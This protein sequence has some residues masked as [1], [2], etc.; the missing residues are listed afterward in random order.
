M[1]YFY[2]DSSSPISTPHLPVYYCFQNVYFF[3]FIHFF[4]FFKQKIHNNTLTGLL[5][6]L[7]KAFYFLLKNECELTHVRLLP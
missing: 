6:T 3:I 1:L 5:M 7:S 2:M 4:I